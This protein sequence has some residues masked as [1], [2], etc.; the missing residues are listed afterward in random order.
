MMLEEA[1]AN[2]IEEY[3]QEIEEE[4]KSIEQDL[5]AIELGE[6]QKKLCNR[7]IELQKI[8]ESI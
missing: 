6:Y 2:W 1:V 7:K 5:E 4:I 8:G 3:K